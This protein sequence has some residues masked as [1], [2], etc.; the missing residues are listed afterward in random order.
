MEWDMMDSASHME[1]RVAICSLGSGVGFRVAS[2]LG[3]NGV[4]SSR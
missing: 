4:S 2:S 1:R 3:R